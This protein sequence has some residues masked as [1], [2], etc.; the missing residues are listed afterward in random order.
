[1][2]LFRELIDF[3]LFKIGEEFGGCDYIIVIYVYE[4]IVNDIKFDFIFK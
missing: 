3:L 1:M 2:Y 4:K